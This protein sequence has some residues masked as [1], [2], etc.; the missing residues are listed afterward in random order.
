MSDTERQKALIRQI[1]KQISGDVDESVDLVPEYGIEG[2]G[3]TFCF[4]PS[5]RS[6]IKIY[7]N[8]VVY[9]LGEYKN[10]NRLLIYT[11]C[12]KIVEIDTDKVYEM[13]FN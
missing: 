11:S 3:Y 12:G 7:I 13:D 9:V 5:S 4:Q 2:S 1:I 10:Q 8:Q 6:F